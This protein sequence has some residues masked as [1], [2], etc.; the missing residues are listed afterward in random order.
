MPNARSF[1]A[2]R[3]LV[4]GA[5][6]GLGRA[7]ALEL[8]RA[9]ARLVITGRSLDRLNETAHQIAKAAPEAPK[10]VLVVADLT[11]DESRHQ[12]VRTVHETFGCL[13]LLVNSAGVG[14]NGPFETHE[15][16]VLRQIIDLNVVALAE[17]TG[18]CLPLL[19][20]GNQ[21]AVLNIGSV[22]CRRGLPGRA[23]YSASKFAVAGFSEAIRAEWSKYGIHVLLLNPG[24]TSTEFEAN[25][26][27]NTSRYKV[28]DRRTTSAASVARRTLKALRQRKNELTLS[29]EGRLLLAIN[30][31]SPRFTDWA[32]AR[33]IRRLYPD[34]TVPEFH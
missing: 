10:P 27:A 12:L 24:F 29:G 17:L 14:A 20:R 5:S 19:C 22:V 21:P 13:D 7:I 8:A 28:T 1:V 30:R 31:V 16:T 15:P 23:A 26:L 18:L 9:E 25:L 4:T 33:W 6:S 34:V 2:S 3:C 32:F 11:V